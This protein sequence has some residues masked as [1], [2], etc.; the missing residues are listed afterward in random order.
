MRATTTRSEPGPAPWTVSSWPFATTWVQRVVPSALSERKP[1]VPAL[2]SVPPEARNGTGAGA[3]VRDTAAGAADA[4][5][6]VGEAAVTAVSAT[7]T[8]IARRFRPRGVRTVCS[9]SSGWFRPL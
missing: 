4:A 1:V 6:T 9:P 5:G 2:S 7:P 8:A 3:A